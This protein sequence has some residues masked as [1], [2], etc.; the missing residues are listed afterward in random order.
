MLQGSNVHPGYGREQLAPGADWVP[1]K[2]ERLYFIVVNVGPEDITLRPG[3]PIAHMQLFL[4]QPVKTKS[5]VPN[6]GWDRLKARLLRPQSDGADGGLSYFRIVKD[7]QQ[8]VR[9]RGADLAGQWASLRQQTEADIKD[10]RRQVAD[11]GKELE[12]RVTADIKEL[13]SQVTEARTAVDRANN[14]SNMVVVFGVFLVSATVLGFALTTLVGLIEKIPGDVGVG[15]AILIAIL[16]ALYAASAV[17][18]VF[19]VWDSVRKAAE[20]GSGDKAS[21]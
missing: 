16:S 18:G 7:L 13:Q 20:G 21:P 12:R 11:D 2:D 17:V 19:L 9:E 14:A 5:A 3:D 1:K 4:V 6:L 10:L 8:E 15:R